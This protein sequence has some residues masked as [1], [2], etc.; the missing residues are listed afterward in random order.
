MH[1]VPQFCEGNINQAYLGYW[2]NKRI[3]VSS[4]CRKM[5]YLFKYALGYLCKV[6]HLSYNKEYL[7]PQAHAAPMLAFTSSALTCLVSTFSD[8]WLIQFCMLSPGHCTP[9]REIRHFPCR[10]LGY[11]IL[12]H[13]EHEPTCY[14]EFSLVGGLD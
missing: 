8:E 1:T 9:Q 13:Q 14:Q 2:K 11:P 12:F 5:E 6:P 7:L 3:A 4:V 10:L